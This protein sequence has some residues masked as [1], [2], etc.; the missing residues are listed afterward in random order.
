MKRTLL[1]IIALVITWMASSAFSQDDW[2][3]ALAI[4]DVSNLTFDTT[5]ATFDGSPHCILGPNIWFCYTASCT[6]D[7]TVSLQ[8]SSYDTMLAIYDGCGAPGA[9]SMLKCNDDAPGGG[10]HSEAT[11]AATAGSEYLIEIGGY[12]E[13]T[14]QG[15]LTISCEGAI[16]AEIDIDPDTLNL[17]NKGKWITC[18]IELPDGLD[19]A[20]I[21]VSTIM[22]NGE[23]QAEPRPAKIGDYDSDGVIDLMVKFDRSAVQQILDVGNQVEITIAGELADGTLFEGMDTIRVIEKEKQ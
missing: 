5:D 10:Y 9:L 19:A 4:G 15:I 12:D 22:L 17:K 23:V 6:G 16:E 8:G 11:F 14:G 18:Y 2:E 1:R 20:D 21:D 13:D 7:V 3:D